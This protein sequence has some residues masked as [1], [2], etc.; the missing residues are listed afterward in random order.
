MNSHTFKASVIG[1]GHIG[2]PVFES[3]VEHYGFNCR[4]DGGHIVGVDIA[5]SARDRAMQ[6]IS[7]E[8]IHDSVQVRVT[9]LLEDS[10]IYIIAIYSPEGIIKMLT[11]EI[12]NINN[13]NGLIIIEST[14]EP[15]V[16][17]DERFGGNFAEWWKENHPNLKLVAYPHRLVPY[18]M[19][20]FGAFDMVRV[21]GGVGEDD[22]DRAIDLYH[23]IGRQDIKKTSFNTA[24]LAKAFENAIRFMEIAFAQH[25]WVMV[26]N[27][28]FDVDQ[29]HRVGPQVDFDEL[30]EAMNSKWNI[31]LKEVRDGIAGSCLPKDTKFS[32][33]F[34]KGISTEN[35][36][37]I[38]LASNDAFAEYIGK[39]KSVGNETR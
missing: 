14:L 9:G 36:F 20:N 17:S 23:Y 18:D 12:P 10:D 30:R 11:E 33:D 7:V 8:D 24:V 6:A 25:L 3:L 22:V 34:F 28:N 35:I 39:V 32:A 15:S 2:M 38:A 29:G 21:M 26:R 37:E 5:P 31:D 4:D 13:G 27:Y 19:E 1:L 16:L